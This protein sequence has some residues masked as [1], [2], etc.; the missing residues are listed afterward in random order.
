MLV[1]KIIRN[2]AVLLDDE[3]FLA[4]LESADKM[5]DQCVSIKNKLVECVNIVNRKIAT[6]YC[7]IKLKKV[8]KSNKNNIMI[9]DISEEE[10]IEILQL[11]INGVK[12]V[13]SVENG[14]LIAESGGQMTITY[15][16][17]PKTLTY[18][19][20]IDYYNNKVNDNI[21]AYGVVSEYLYIM[22]NFVDAKIWEEKFLKEMS[23]INSRHRD[24][25]MPKRGWY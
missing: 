3:E 7:P 6:S 12:S 25:V 21:F 14:Y 13:F 22:G 2:C 1:S 11:S 9:S 8:L 19:D 18:T 20:N 4:E 23:N 15:T 24:I 16:I 5:S 10:I 17:L